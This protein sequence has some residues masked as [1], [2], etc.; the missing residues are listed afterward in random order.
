M[1]EKY[2][3]ELKDLQREKNSATDDYRKYKRNG[4][5]L[6]FKIKKIED[7]NILLN[8]KLL[9]FNQKNEKFALAENRIRELL[10]KLR[11]LEDELREKE[12]ENLGLKKETKEVERHKQALFNYE[13]KTKSLLDENERFSR[14]IQEKSQDIEKWRDECLSLERLK[15]R[16]K[17]MEKENKE[18]RESQNQMAEERNSLKKKYDQGQELLTRLYDERDKIIQEHHELSM[19]CDDKLAE[20]EKKT[21]VIGKL[22]MKLF[23]ALAEL[24]RNTKN[25]NSS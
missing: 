16:F 9:E 10:N 20:N 22:R 21:A 15:S 3:S 2:S 24:D 4:E 7:E 12:D 13:E 23:L 6:S 1:T 25:S 8:D 14:I 18:M 19:I 11:N 5:E 17:D